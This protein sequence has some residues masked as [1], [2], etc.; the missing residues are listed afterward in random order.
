MNNQNKSIDIPEKIKSVGGSGIAMPPESGSDSNNAGEDV[1]EQS[2]SSLVSR[3]GLNPFKIS[4]NS[5]LGGKH[6]ALMAAKRPI[7]SGLK[8][9][10]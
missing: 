3:S 9:R 8:N 1:P 4:A 7:I 2:G 10:N 5:F 6:S